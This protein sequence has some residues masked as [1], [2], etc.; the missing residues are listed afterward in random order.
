MPKKTDLSLPV[1]KFLRENGLNL[2]YEH[3]IIRLVKDKLKEEDDKLEKQASEEHTRI[4]DNTLIQ[5]QS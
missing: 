1:Q 2:K 3:S 5:Y 4:A